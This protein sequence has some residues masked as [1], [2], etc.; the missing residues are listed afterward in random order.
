MG[1]NADLDISPFG[2]NNFYILNFNDMPSAF[3]TLFCCLR[4]SDFDVVANGMVTVSTP[5]ARLYFVFYYILGVLLFLN[6]LQ[7]YF[8]VVFRP[9][10]DEDGDDK[11]DS[12]EDGSD[13]GSNADSD[14]DV[15]EETDTLYDP[16]YIDNVRALLKSD[17]SALPEL[18]EINQKGFVIDVAHL[19]KL[20]V[21]S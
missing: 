7:S 6:I 17:I 2:K 10:N 5:W 1:V 21:W 13:A 14:S 4:I 20:Q 8:V 15:E 3:T 19:A 16:E 18:E 11:K 12:K 9:K